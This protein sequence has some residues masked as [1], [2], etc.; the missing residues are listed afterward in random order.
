M[1]LEDDH[2]RRTLQGLGRK[3]SWPIETEKNNENLFGDQ[4][5]IRTGH[6]S[7]T[8]QKRYSLSQRVKEV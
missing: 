5:E 7:N 6:L 4:A 3:R 8:Y 1:I 2:D